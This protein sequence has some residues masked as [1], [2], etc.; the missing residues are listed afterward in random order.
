MTSKLTP[1]ACAI[2]L[3]TSNIYAEDTKHNFDI[4]SQSLETA[5]QKLASQSGKAMLFAEYAVKGKQSTGLKGQYSTEEALNSLLKNSGLTFNINAD[6]TVMLKPETEDTNV[7]IL[8]KVIVSDKKPAAGSLSQTTL[9]TESLQQ[10][11]GQIQDTAKLLEDIPGV[12]VQA[13]GGVS[14]LPV[15]RGLNDDRVKVE[16]DGMTIAA[17]CGNHMNPPLSY[18]DRT[19]VGKID[20]FQSVTPVSLGGDSIGGTIVVQSADP[21]FAEAGK[22]VLIDGQLS[23]FYRSNGD[24]FGGSITTGIANQNARLEYT[25]SH[26]ESQNYNDGNGKVIESTAYENQNHAVKLAYKLDNH[27]F[28]FKGGQQHIPLQG[29]PNQRM[30]MLKNDSIF[31]NL[32]YKGDYDWGKLDGKLFLENTTHFMDIGYDKL[33]PQPTGTSHSRMPMD[34]RGQNLGY[35]LQAEIPFGQRDTLRVGNEFHANKLNEWWD[36]VAPNWG[37]IYNA[38]GGMWPDPFQNLNNATRDRLGTFVEWE[39]NWTPELKSLLGLRYDHTVTDAGNV[40]GYYNAGVVNS[41]NRASLPIAMLPPPVASNYWTQGR[42]DS[43]VKALNE[44]STWNGMSHERNFDTFDISALLQ[45]TPNRN[46]QYEFG[47]A[48]KNRAPG[49]YDLYP[50]STSAMM[51]SMMGSFGDGNGYVGNINLKEETAHNISFTAEFHDAANESWQIKATPYFSYV[52]NFID[53]DRC[54][55]GNANCSV[56]AGHSYGMQPTNG[57]YF[58]SMNNHD[59][60]LWGADLSARTDLFKDPTLGSFG[61]R[62]V[63]SYVRGER[64]DGGNLYHMM[65]F[66]AKL[67]LDHKKEG[68]RNSV[69]MQFVDGKSD[70]QKIRNELTTPAYILLNA[71]TGYT[72]QNL[73]IDVGLDNILDKQY[74]H[75]L[76]G[77][78]ASDYYAMSITFPDPGYTNNR[79]LPGMGRSAFIGFT[80]KY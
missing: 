13:N 49:I 69:E 6:G 59:A 48:R 75:P 76:A 58:L 33:F 54:G 16:V 1:L 70:V 22:G 60:R 3:A 41:L 63:M 68:W 20:V 36:P 66:N 5:L 74:Y 53:V 67:A 2:V 11:Q 39:A 25:G 77:V 79:N 7:T 40:H 21:V 30:D 37:P 35:K 46:S 9:S 44:A 80:L 57:F 29:F 72:Y 61:A 14:S 62:T 10:K 8:D 51:M 26:S 78:N 12:T 4:P 31:G 65:P 73:T 32:H 43:A 28:E 38:W 45:Y 15:I 50:W 64:M 23:G 34:V 47:Y 71:R 17:A 27:L 24:S 18:I 42:Y 55:T 56:S 52:E 19:N